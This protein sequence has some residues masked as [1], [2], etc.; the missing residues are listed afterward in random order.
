MRERNGI[1]LPFVFRSEAQSIS[2][3][4]QRVH[5]DAT[6]HADQ[7]AGWDVLHERFLTKRINHEERYSDGEAC[8]NMA[9]SFFSPVLWRNCHKQVGAIA[10]LSRLM[11]SRVIEIH[12]GGERRDS[13]GGRNLPWRRV[14]GQFEF[15]IRPSFA[16]RSFR[17]VSIQSR[18][19]PI[20][21]ITAI[22]PAKKIT[23]IASCS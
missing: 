2:I 16:L 17:R 14:V 15:L 23:I 8:T 13:L 4:A 10:P 12:H 11:R 21:F 22:K 1:T 6:I 18:P 19:I 7:A 20:S 9:E 5:P 3:I